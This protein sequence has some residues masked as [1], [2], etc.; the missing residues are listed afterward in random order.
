MPVCGAFLLTEDW[1]EIWLYLWRG[2]D[3]CVI[4]EAHQRAGNAVK[5]EKL[6][7]HQEP[8]QRCRAKF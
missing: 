6:Q 5:Y 2:S 4:M 3:G 7:M 1:A 8:P